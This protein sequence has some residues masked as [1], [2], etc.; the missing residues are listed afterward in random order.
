MSN[1]PPRILLG[2]PFSEKKRYIIFEWLE[3]VRQLTYPNLDI[4]LVDNSPTDTIAHEVAALGFK[5]AM[6]E[7]KGKSRH[8]ITKSQ[9]TI[10][11]FFLLGNYDYLFSLE[12]DNFPP[13]NVIELMLAQRMDNINV[14]YLLDRETGVSI[15]VQK[16]YRNIPTEQKANVLTPYDSILECDGKI[17]EYAAPSIGCSLFSKQLMQS[18][19][20][21][22]DEDNPGAFSDSFFHVD[23]RSAGFTPYVMTGQFCDHKRISWHYNKQA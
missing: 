4:F 6:V 19:K 20:F 22:V 1:N 9:N 17:K 2:T 12:C 16:F 11:Q 23:S 5:V 7:P 8:F 15:G 3:M 21:R 10:R 14:P 18:V 13:L